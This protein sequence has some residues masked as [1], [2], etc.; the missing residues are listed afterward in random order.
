MKQVEI[1]QILYVEMV[2]ELASPFG[3]GVKVHYDMAAGHGARFRTGHGTCE[4]PDG[5]GVGL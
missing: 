4:R 5:G 3:C 1:A 2:S